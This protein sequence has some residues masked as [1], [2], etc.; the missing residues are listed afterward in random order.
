[1]ADRSRTE[2]IQSDLPVHPLPRTA[3]ALLQVAAGTAAGV[4]VGGLVTVA[5]PMTAA[6]GALIGWDV[7]VAVYL[8]WVWRSSWR[9][10]AE[11]TAA[12]AVREDPT[13]AVTD[14]IL[15]VAA[16]TSLAAVVYTIADAS[17]SSGWGEALRV[18]LGIASIVCSWFLVHTLFVM[19]YAREYFAGTDGGIDF[20]MRR[21]PVWSDFAYLS[22]TIGMTFQV[23]DTDLET[24]LLRRIALRHM[25]ISYL[26]GAVIIAV[27]IN[28]VAGLTK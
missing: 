7:A 12:A 25:L 1:M 14:V 4:L 16:V 9:L 10:D 15:L 6:Y 17:R 11:G 5:A 28:L 23:S 18:V 20:N 26:F 13:R 19:S 21:P 22:F 2:R 8:A 24:S 27:T 3:R